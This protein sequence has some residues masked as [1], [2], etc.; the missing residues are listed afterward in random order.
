MDNLKIANNTREMRCEKCY[1]L[2]DL[3]WL[4]IN[5]RLSVGY[6]CRSHKRQGDGYYY[7]KRF[8]ILL[9]S[10]TSVIGVQGLLKEIRNGWYE[11][12]PLPKKQL[13]IQMSL[14]AY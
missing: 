6:I 4:N 13:G 10:L 3:T 11:V 1:R 12:M 8:S 5:A 14:F 9:P 2:H 7:I